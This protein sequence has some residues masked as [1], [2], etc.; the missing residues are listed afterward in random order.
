MPFS[1]SFMDAPPEHPYEN[2]STKAARGII[3]LGD[4]TEEFLAN[5]HEWTQAEY[6]EQWRRSIRSLIAGQKR[7]VLITT[8]SS[9]TVASHLE[10]W[11]LYREGEEVFAQNQLLFFDGLEDEFDASRAVDFLRERQT[12]NEE[13]LAISEW[14]VSMHDVRVFGKLLGI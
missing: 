9:P 6:R 3:V 14:S 7:A 11:A 1:I 2:R 8:F 12:E 13:G 10:W 5:L 4:S